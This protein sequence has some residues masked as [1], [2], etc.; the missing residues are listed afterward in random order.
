M[1]A[2]YRSSHCAVLTLETA[3]HL[4]TNVVPICLPSLSD[5]SKTYEGVTATVAGWGLKEDGQESVEQ[6][7][8]VDVPIISNTEC[9]KSYKWLKRYISLPIDT[10]K[11]KSV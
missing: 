8:S 11:C 6:L 1:H 7:M 3:V 5:T 9:E 4:T 2:L 10:Q